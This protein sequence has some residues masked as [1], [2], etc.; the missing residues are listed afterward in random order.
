[1]W[2]VEIVPELAARA[3]G[4]LLEDLGLANV[5]LREG[6]GAL[7]WPEAAPFDRILVTA[8]APWVPPPLRAQL[9]PGGR[10]VL[11]VGE[12]ESDQVLRVLERGADGIEEIEDVLP[13]RFVPLTHRPPAV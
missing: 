11:P 5:H 7:G 8:A 6:D 10:M 3:R 9:A 4:L 13:V 1:V 12:A 2:S